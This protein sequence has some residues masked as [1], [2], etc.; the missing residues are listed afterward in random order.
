MNPRK[1]NVC[2]KIQPSRK[3]PVGIV[4]GTC[5]EKTTKEIKP[6]Q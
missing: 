5:Q 6:I 3:N 2:L 4:S 1:G